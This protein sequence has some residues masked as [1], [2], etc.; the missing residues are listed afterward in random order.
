VPSCGHKQRV[1]LLLLPSTTFE[2]LRFQSK[3]YTSLEEAALDML[4][5]AERIVSGFV[6]QTLL[7]ACAESVEESIIRFGPYH[8]APK[9]SSVGPNTLRIEN[10]PFYTP[11]WVHED[12]ETGLTYKVWANPLRLMPTLQGE[13]WEKELTAREGFTITP[14]SSGYVWTARTPWEMK[15]G[16]ALTKEE[17]LSFLGS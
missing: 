2:Y 14:F 8:K 5:E 10:G 7:K 17:A 16:F 11:G 15:R 4:Q 12:P 1:F 9:A 6:E 3:N 13:V